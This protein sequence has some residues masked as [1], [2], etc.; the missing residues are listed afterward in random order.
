M[1]FSR[2]FCAAAVA[3]CLLGALA[4]GARADE[5]FGRVWEE[6][7]D[8]EG[9]QD[10]ETPNPVPG[11]DPLP[12]DRPLEGVKVYL[13]DTSIPEGQPGWNPE[14][15]KTLADGTFSF[16]N[17]QPDPR[18]KL[19]LYNLETYILPEHRGQ[20]PTQFDPSV[21]EEV[22]ATYPYKGT[23]VYQTIDFD[24]SNP[25]QMAEEVNQDPPKDTRKPETDPLGPSTGL[26]DKHRA[27]FPVRKGSPEDQ[28]PFTQVGPITGF[29]Y[30]EVGAPDGRFDFDQDE[31]VGG[32]LLRLTVQRTGGTEETSD[33]VS[34]TTA[35][36]G[37]FVFATPLLKPV[38]TTLGGQ[39]IYR[40][41]DVT[42][43]VRDAQG[44]P[45]GEPF[46]V[47]TRLDPDVPASQRNEDTE[48]QFK[49]LFVP[50]GGAGALTGRIEGV[51]F[52][53]Q[54]GGDG[55][56]DPGEP[57]ADMATVT[58]YDE[59]DNPVGD[60]V[61]TQAD[62]FFAFTALPDGAYR[63]EARLTTGQT[64][65]SF[66]GIGRGSTSVE[67]VAIE[68]D[69]TLP[70]PP[71][72]PCDLT[73]P[74]TSGPL[75]EVL[76]EGEF[77][78][79]A[80]PSGFDV[81]ATLHDGCSC[82]SGVVDSVQLAYDGLQFP[83][84]VQGMDGVLAIQGV[85]MQPGTGWATVRLRMTAD[86]SAF[87]DGSF[88]TAARRVDVRV[89]GRLSAV[90]WRFV[91]DTTQAGTTFGIFRVLSTVGRDVWA[92]CT[93]FTPPVVE[94]PLP[95][96]PCDPAPPVCPPKPACQPKPVCQ[97]KP[98]CTPKAKSGKSAKK[99][100]KSSKSRSSGKSKKSKKHRTVRA[101]KSCAKRSW[102][103]WRR[104]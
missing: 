36:A 35:L 12:A 74:C 76:F 25:Q 96:A 81:K 52:I 3:L 44:N 37:Q 73:V 92:D 42:I 79:G 93:D 50:V 95:P 55:V 65:Q 100:G 104:R 59:D 2:M 17:Y 78:V 38:A 84:P 6:V 9:Y 77:W 62:G 99:S 103:R 41:P 7:N 102:S 49:E 88:G 39:T 82:R 89:N 46:V 71:P 29:T 16:L 83:G 26:T 91:C 54:P 60:P 20:K 22:R 18:Y 101:R 40:A 86:P 4:Q 75:H 67:N 21:P 69:T 33:T 48:V 34:S 72:P 56:K 31:L 57:A 14:W 70:P 19:Q 10:T 23:V 30:R 5:L 85:T 58:L 27:R 87:P 98:A 45:V 24:E 53:E 28:D 64:G 66:T 13:I 63:L 68:V 51:A 90:C 32:V 1:R 15:K 80:M 43:Q 94:P 8:L 11:G 61:L 47:E 97:P